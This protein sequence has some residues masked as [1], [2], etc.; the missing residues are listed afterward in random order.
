MACLFATLRGPDLYKRLKSRPT[1][2]ASQYGQGAELWS[3]AQYREAFEAIPELK[4]L[5]RTPFM[6]QVRRLR[7]TA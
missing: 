1:E 2:L 6:Q 3:F 5:V 7:S 4:E